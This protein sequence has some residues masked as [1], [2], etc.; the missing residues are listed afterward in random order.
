[1]NDKELNGDYKRYIKIYNQRIEVNESEAFLCAD[2]KKSDDKYI[3]KL[4]FSFPLKYMEYICVERGDAFLI[5]ILY[6]AMINGYDLILEKPVSNK[7]LFQLTTYYIPTL[8]DIT[9][10][11]HLINIT[12]ETDNTKIQ[13]HKAVGTALSCGVDS[14]YT[15]LKSLESK[16]DDYKLTHILFTSIPA[17]TYAED[18]KEF[19]LK[20]SYHK[21]EKVS[22]ELGLDFIPCDTNLILE[23]AIEP[24]TTKSGVLVSNEGLASL[25]YCSFA[26]A[27][28]K[29]FQVYYLGSAG[30]K[31]NEADLD[32]SPYDVLWHD[33]FSMPLISTENLQFYSSGVE[34]SRI[35]K[36][37]FIADYPIVQKYL[38]G[39]AMPVV[40]NCG[41]CEKCIRTMSE[42]YAVG[43]LE[44][45]SNI[46]PVK[47]YKS[48]MGYNM[49]VVRAHKKKPF[50]R[51]IL[52][53]MRKKGNR[54]P[55]S[56][57]PISLI[58]KWEE[59]LRKKLHNVQILR[60]IYYSLGLDIKKYGLSTEKM[61]TRDRS[62]NK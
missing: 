15:V 58:L 61:R 57:Y 40:D 28:Q 6:Y 32:A 50:N 5:A 22:A 48:H 52:I 39:C 45:F 26:F 36:V 60:K 37:K 1:M 55:I 17:F 46:Y 20:S 10:F 47:K 49:A 13:N 12:A 43:K 62:L 4:W 7:L 54:I 53:M 41:K 23:F 21:V 29:L 30:Y 27:L 44:L 19:W 9:S 18:L 35:E 11:F 25:P 3:K 31:L 34:A 38:L 51:D 24:F 56:S 59:W 16:F 33:F 14:F 8:L 2:I 42:L